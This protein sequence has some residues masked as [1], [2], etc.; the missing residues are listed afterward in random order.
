[1]FATIGVI[2]AAVYMLYMF[3]KVFMGEVVSEENKNLS[4]ITWQEYAV[5]IPLI[6]VIFWI[7]LQPAVFFHAMDASVNQ[8]VQQVSNAAGTVAATVVK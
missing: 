4:P 2:L 3:Q 5:L 1:M 6:V 7:G 8:V